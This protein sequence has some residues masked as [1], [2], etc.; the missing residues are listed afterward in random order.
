M[1]ENSGCLE[2]AVTD[3][4]Q[5]G[6]AARWF[7][8]P[9]SR[10]VSWLT[11]VCEGMPIDSE[12][13][14]SVDD[15][16]WERIASYLSDEST[17]EDAAATRDWLAAH[18]AEATS[19]EALSE[20]LD[21]LGVVSTRP[22]DVDAAAR[23][24]AE[25]RRPRTLAFRRD[26]SSRS[27]ATR[28]TGLR[29]A[30][31]L[32]LAVTG[33][34]FWRALR[35]D[36]AGPA[37]AQSYRAETGAPDSIRLADGTL[38]ILAPHAELDIREGFGTTHRDVELKGLGYFDVAKNEAAPFVVRAGTAEIRD[39]GTAFTVRA[40]GVEGVRVAVHQ[41]IVIVREEGASTN[42]GIVLKAGDHATVGAGAEIARGGVSEN[43]LQWTSGR[44][45]F[46]DTPVSELVREIR[47]WYGINLEVSE[48]LAGRGVNTDLTDFTVPQ[49]IQT[50][51]LALSARAV[52]RGDTV[53][54]EA[55]EGAKR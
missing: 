11:R 51:E 18:P 15:Q 23:R 10:R 47:R 42:D 34:L 26:S 30:A 43:E 14:R 38:A 20:A 27:W 41:G 49:V 45:V 19:I 21:R 1:Q 13:Y 52:V 35:S 9:E 32:A 3:Q 39:I 46:R 16:H 7:H 29:I 40:D 54:L 2:T 24:S 44:L 48:E 28:S 50:L 22:I 5:T 25:L 55:R 17:P 4:P 12:D 53:R 31:G 6:R 36:E 8:V 33:G 37:V